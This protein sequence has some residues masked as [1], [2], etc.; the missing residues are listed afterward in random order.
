MIKPQLAK[1]DELFK[2]LDRFD[3]A[4]RKSRSKTNRS[5]DP[6]KKIV[7]EVVEVKISPKQE[8]KKPEVLDETGA[9]S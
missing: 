6:S 8:P 4:N 1:A 3:S 5:K 2:K 9:F 7:E